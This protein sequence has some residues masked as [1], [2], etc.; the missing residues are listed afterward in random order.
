[1]KRLTIAASLLACMHAQAITLD[2]SQGSHRMT[3]YQSDLAL[4]TSQF[5]LTQPNR[6]LIIE[7]LPRGLMPQSVQAEALPIDRQRW[8]TGASFEQRLTNRLGDE[9]TLVHLDSQETRTGR[10]V[11][12][13]GAQL[14]FE[15]RG[16]VLRYPLNGPWQ[17]QLN[18]YDPATTELELELAEPLPAQE[19]ALSYL[20]QGFSWQAEYQIELQS[21]TDLNLIGR[22]ALINQTET[23]MQLK[24]L[25]LLA[26]NPKTPAGSA[27][28]MLET[29]VMAMAMADSQPS[30]A[31]H[32]GYQLFQLDGEHRLEARGTQRVPLLAAEGLPAQVTY[33]ARHSAYLGVQPG[34]QQQY[35]QQ[36]LRFELDEGRL[37]V[38]LPA[39]EATL[40]RRDASGQLQFVGAQRLQQFSP[41]EVVELNYGEVFDLKV[42]RRQTA[43]QRNGDVF[44]QSYEVRLINGS[45]RP[46]QLAYLLEANS[47]WSLV[48]ASIAGEME[49]T[50]GRWQLEVPARSEL[51]LSYTLRM[52]R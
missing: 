48:E 32:Q 4:I 25:T 19:F 2:Q 7:G 29:R 14:E 28:P 8:R 10:L 35:A 34:V 9:L 26:G 37:N 17:P 42:E 50:Q 23:P 11:G 44:L 33:Q 18:A 43:Y 5:P 40:F 52:T 24:A 20:T 45:G 31:E 38:P 3:L 6:S 21:D 49:G 47:P 39:G 22:A 27:Q 1:M 16:S 12:F 36:Q 51:S 46:R 30:A 13:N 15:Y 41:A